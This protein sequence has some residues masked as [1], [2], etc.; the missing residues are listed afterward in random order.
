MTTDKR[1]KLGLFLQFQNPVEVEGVGFINF[2]HL[3]K[4]SLAEAA[5]STKDFMKEVKSSIS[6]LKMGEDFHRKV[7]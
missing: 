5:S 2:L 6:E 4:Q 7:A 3:A 1:A